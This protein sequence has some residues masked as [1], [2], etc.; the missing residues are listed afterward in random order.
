M[1]KKIC[2]KSNK[3]N[4]GLETESQ[5]GADRHK[6]NISSSR[7]RSRSAEKENRRHHTSNR[8][9][10]ETGGHYHS[11]SGS[12]TDV[13]SSSKKG[14]STNHSSGGRSWNNSPRNYGTI[15]PGTGAETPEGPSSRFAQLGKDTPRSRSKWT[16]HLESELCRLWQEE[17]HLYDATLNDYRRQDRRLSAIRRIAGVLDMEG[18][19]NFSCPVPNSK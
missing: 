11:K 16:D 1:K 5:T 10:T 9:Y 14:L 18:W 19:H 2:K 3:K 7:S 6:K 15:S 8:N 4:Q 13:R 17:R 12:S